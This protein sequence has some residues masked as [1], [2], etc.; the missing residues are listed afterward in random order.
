LLEEEEDEDEAE[1]EVVDF[2]REAEEEDSRLLYSQIRSLKQRWKRTQTMPRIWMPRQ[3][4]H[5]L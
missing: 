2:L 3:H 1:D 5:V 4:L